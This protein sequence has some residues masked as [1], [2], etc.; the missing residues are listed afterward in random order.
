MAK[1]NVR[2]PL[3]TDPSE[4]IALL[5]KVKAKHDE[6]GAA[7]PL[8]GLKWEKVISPALAIAAEQEAS[9]TP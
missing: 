9:P 5:T 2:I 4:T 7:S 8:T 6:L 3:P 1:S